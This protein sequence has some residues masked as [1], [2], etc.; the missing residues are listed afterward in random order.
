MLQIASPHI[1]GVGKAHMLIGIPSNVSSLI[2][3]SNTRVLMSLYIVIHAII[4]H[5]V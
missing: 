5:S 1:E 3:S 2:W 4:I